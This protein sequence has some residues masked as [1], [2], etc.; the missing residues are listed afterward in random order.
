MVIDTLNMKA[1]KAHSIEVWG[2][3]SEQIDDYTSRGL[4]DK[5]DDPDGARLWKMVDPYS[6][7]DRLTMPK[8]MIN[9]LN[10]RYWTLDALNIYWGELKGPE[11]GRLFAERRS[12]PRGQ[13]PLR[14]QRRRRV[15]PPH[16]FPTPVAG[17]KLESRRRRRGIVAPDRHLDARTESRQALVGP[18]RQPRL[19]RV[20]LGCDRDDDRRQFRQGRDVPPRE[21]VRRGRGRRFLRDRW[22]RVSS[23]DTSPSNH[24]Q[25][26]AE[27]S[28]LV[29]W[30]GASWRHVELS[31]TANAASAASLEPLS[32]RERCAG[33]EAG[34]RWKFDVDA[35]YKMAEVGILKREDRV[36]LI[37]GDIV[38]MSPIGRF[39]ASADRRLTVRLTQ[40]FYGRACVSVNLPVRLNVNSEPQP[41]F[42][43]LHPRDDYYQ[44]G[45]PTPEDV[46]FLVEVMDSSAAFDRG[47][48]LGV[49]ARPAWRRSGLSM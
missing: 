17:I 30:G 19:P 40:L 42:S 44:S 18:L 31:T 27:S 16:D 29:A 4:T 15:V 7:R 26:Q 14:G 20:V 10:D 12:Q 21:G 45:H 48:K 9:G 38:M 22:H 8:L 1:Q 34:T 46:F 41:D 3:F 43:I 25:E 35:Y 5:F 11:I 47:T 33:G 23:V 36:E 13:S 24:R 32:P 39:H 6:Y 2:K 37:D 28:E 49:Y